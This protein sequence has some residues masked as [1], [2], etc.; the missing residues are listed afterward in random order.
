MP[1][2]ALLSAGE[3]EGR[4]AHAVEHQALHAQRLYRDH[5]KFSLLQ[6]RRCSVPPCSGNFL[7]IVSAVL[8]PFLSCLSS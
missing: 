5:M 8:R 3:T 4:L 2:A 6:L 1:W 7:R